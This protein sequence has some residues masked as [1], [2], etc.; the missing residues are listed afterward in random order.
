MRFVGA[1]IRP[2]GTCYTLQVDHWYGLMSGTWPTVTTHTS[3][4]EAVTA[5]IASRCGNEVSFETPGGQK[6]SSYI[7]YLELLRV[8]AAGRALPQVGPAEVARAPLAQQVVGVAR[9]IVTA[10][11]HVQVVQTSE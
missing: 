9:P 11:Q 8:A 2:V 10:S 5:L 3:L 7:E 1:S 6:T 4:D